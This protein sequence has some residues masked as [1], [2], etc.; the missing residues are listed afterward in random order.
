L[1][2]DLSKRPPLFILPIVLMVIAS[3]AGA[4]QSPYGE[5]SHSKNEIA[6]AFQASQ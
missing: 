1:L 3:A 4:K 6:S 2:G 5:A